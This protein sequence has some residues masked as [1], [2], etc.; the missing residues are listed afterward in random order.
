[1]SLFSHAQVYPIVKF[2]GPKIQALF[3]VEETY[4]VPAIDARSV[5]TLASNV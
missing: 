3:I 1:M 4:P 2:Q 5:Y